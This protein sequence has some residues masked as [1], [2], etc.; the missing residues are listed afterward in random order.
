MIACRGRVEEEKRVD[1]RDSLSRSLVQLSTLFIR[2]GRVL[3]SFRSS[4][5]DSGPG[6]LGSDVLIDTRLVGY[7]S[8]PAG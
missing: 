6:E 4:D 2:D 3:S 8:A 5:L 7:S 1:K